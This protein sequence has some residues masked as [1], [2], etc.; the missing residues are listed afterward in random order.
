MFKKSIFKSLLVAIATLSIISCSKEIPIDIITFD[1]K[2]LVLN[3]GNF[4]EH[5]A[6]LSLYDE[7]TGTMQ[8]RVYETANGVSIGATIVSGAISPANQAYLV[9]NNPDKIEIIDPKTAKIASASITEG[10]ESPR[11]AIITN[12]RIYVSNWGN[13]YNVLPSGF[14]E[15]NKSYIA[16]YDLSTK[17]LIKKVL[18]GTDAEGMVIFGNRLFVAVKEGVRVFDISTDNLNT[19][20]TIRPTGVTGAAKHLTYDSSAKIWASFP[21]KGVVRI[22]P[23]YLDVLS[24]VEVPVDYM[25]GYITTDAYGTQIYTYNT[26]FNASYMPE[27][28]SIYSVDSHSGNVN[29][30]FT[31][32]YF[33]GLGVSPST[34]NIFTAEVSFTSNSLMK[35]VGA[36][37]NLKSSAP[38]G[39]GTFRY[40]FF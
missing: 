35:V 1:K 25:D 39:V 12:N 26:T 40:L 31:G 3:Q 9:C 16:V 33:Y 21:D 7:V 27:E 23:I 6:S 38:A 5:S 17:V 20:A 36:D 29:K 18:A 4:T 10:L 34:G 24:I 13:E 11:N 14:W 2:V 28:A 22:D 8:N 30:L 19:I 32:T 15:F 37:G